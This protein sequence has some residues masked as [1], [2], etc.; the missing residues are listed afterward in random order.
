MFGQTLGDH[1]WRKRKIGLS[2]EVFLESDGNLD[3]TYRGMARLIDGPVTDP[4]QATW[5]GQSI[6]TTSGRCIRDSTGNP[7]WPSDF[8]WWTP[9]NSNCEV[10]SLGRVIWC[11]LDYTDEARASGATGRE[12][13]RV[14]E[15]YTV[16]ELPEIAFDVSYQAKFTQFEEEQTELVIFIDTMHLIEPASVQDRLDVHLDYDFNPTSPTPPPLGHKFFARYF[17]SAERLCFRPAR[18]TTP[19]RA[20][21]E[22]ATFSRQYLEEY[23]TN[24]N[25]IS[26]PFSLFIDAFGLFRNM[27]RSIMG[28]YLIPQFLEKKIRNRRKSLLPLTLGP[29]GASL[30]D[31]VESLAHLASLDEG[32]ELQVGGRT[33][34]ICSFIASIIGDMPS[35]QLLAGCLGPKANMPCRYCIVSSPERPNLDF[36][37]VEFGRYAEQ[38]SRD[39]ARI[40]TLPNKT[41]Q[42]KALRD[43]GLHSDWRLMSALGMFSHRSHFI[44]LI[45][46]I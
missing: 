16:E 33:V 26:L 43:L 23:F 24:P 19:L 25:T 36:N 20:E 5:W 29:F 6:R 13:L 39:I 14:Q 8:V 35:Q 32:L 11:G 21:K 28:F 40:K 30:A 31:I 17:F 42:T 9:S 4:W 15:V 1:D 18:L 34:F 45:I 27:Y 12:I 37:I 41:R 7:I 22:L 44:V 38:T 2:L 46:H 10:R 3:K